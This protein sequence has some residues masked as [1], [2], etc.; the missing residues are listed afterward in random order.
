MFDYFIFLRKEHCNVPLHRKYTAWI[1]N[2][3]Y[4]FI[5]DGYNVSL[6]R[7]SKREKWCCWTLVRI[8]YKLTKQARIV[9]HLT[10]SKNNCKLF[11]ECTP[12]LAISTFV[13]IWNYSLSNTSVP[14]SL[15]FCFVICFGSLIMLLASK[16]KSITSLY[17]AS[18]S[19]WLFANVAAMYVLLCKNQQSRMFAAF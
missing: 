2:Y 17:G 5:R 12:D 10:Y 7:M 19:F 18:N 15:K 8:E 1:I 3:T 16:S 4:T 9:R 11:L 14:Q 6:A 13:L